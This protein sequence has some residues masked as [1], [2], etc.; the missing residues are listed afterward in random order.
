MT[1]QQTSP[2]ADAQ[3]YIASARSAWA[4]AHRAA[5]ELTYMDPSIRVHFDSASAGSCEPL[6]RKLRDALAMVERARA[7]LLEVLD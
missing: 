2:A 6:E 7:S 5:T 3:A 1:T 4:G